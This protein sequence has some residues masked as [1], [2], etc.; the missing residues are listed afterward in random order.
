MKSTRRP[1]AGLVRVGLI[2]T[3]LATALT[4][5]AGAQSAHAIDARIDIRGLAAQQLVMRPV[6]VHDAEMKGMHSHSILVP[7]GW[8]FEGGV[9]WNPS[10]IDNFVTFSGRVTAPNTASVDFGP[11][12]VCRYADDETLR[13]AGERL[14]GIGH[15]G[16]LI[17]AAPRRAGEAVLEVVLPRLRQ[18]ATKLVVLSADYH[19]AAEEAF[20]KTI[21]PLL[22]Q[23]ETMNASMRATGMRTDVWYH[24]E[25]VRVRYVED[26]KTWEEEL[27]CTIAGFD[28]T[29]KLPTMQRTMGSWWLSDLRTMRAPQGELEEQLAALSCVARS[30]RPTPQWTTAIQGIQ[31]RIAEIRRRGQLAI[32]DTMRKA[33]EDMRR[34]N[35]EISRSQ[36]DSWRQDQAARDRVFTAMNNSVRGVD[37]Y[38][39]QD[40]DTIAVE[41]HYAHVFRS[42]DGSVIATNDPVYDPNT[43]GA[44]E[45]RDWTKLERV[46]YFR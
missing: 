21:R 11:N 46:D 44:L 29:M 9:R 26:G 38:R 43:D 3:A 17:R 19:R 32:L 14:G 15:D 42:G 23:Q 24:C 7:A 27:H 39:T 6:K 28:T 37:D 8:R 1:Q 18:S 13:F 4:S 2:F 30:L 34:T 40:G 20:A 36:L 10:C 35:E 45:H 12:L 5:C 41:S 16:L 33:R 25:R 31:K 22:A